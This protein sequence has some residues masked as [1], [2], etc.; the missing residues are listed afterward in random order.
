MADVSTSP[1]PAPPAAPV[2]EATAAPEAVREAAAVATTAT[3]K[4]SSGNSVTELSNVPVDAVTEDSS[5]ALVNGASVTAA[6]IEAAE[7][8]VD[9]ADDEAGLEALES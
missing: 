6:A 2:P 4:T 5:A 1:P 3:D 7:E 9:W 8:E